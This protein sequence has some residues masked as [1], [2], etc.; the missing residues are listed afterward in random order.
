MSDSRCDVEF[1]RAGGPLFRWPADLGRRLEDEGWTGHMEM[2]SQ[3]LAGDPYVVLAAAA[4]MT[5]SLGLATGVTNP[6]TRNLAVTA[7]AIA[8]VQAQ[9]RGRAVLGIGRGDSALAYLGQ[10][11][12]SV[13]QFEQSLATLQALLRGEEVAFEQLGPLPEER[14]MQHGHLA[15]G[16]W[17]TGAA[18][19]WLPPDLPKVPI[20]VA[21]TGPRVIAA[22]ARLADRLTLSLGADEELLTPAIAHARSVRAQAGHDPD[23]FPIGA[24][25][26]II[27]HHDRTEARQLARPLVASLARFRVLDRR[28]EPDS[29][30]AEL[31]RISRDY[32]M[33]RHSSTDKLPDDALSDE[34]VDRFAIV[35]PVEHCVERLCGLVEAGLRHF[36]VVGVIFTREAE[37]LTRRLMVTEVMPAV[38]HEAARSS[39]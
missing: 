17:P 23:D 31:E 37:E 25:V 22:G 28:P 39:G 16:N 14:S 10:R 3:S 30:E 36:H 18:L 8:S 11:P 33:D 12:A 21:A 19:R 34:F 6:L 26:V 5:T 24:Q 35:G 15:G 2:D 29:S 1:W 32:D 13:E 4:T 38:R 7:A 27:P 9:S 20:D